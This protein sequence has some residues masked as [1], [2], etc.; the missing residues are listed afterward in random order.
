[1]ETVSPSSLYLDPAIREARAEYRHVN[2][3][4]IMR[5]MKRHENFKVRF[6]VPA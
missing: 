5:E 3:Q 6:A 4:S 1:M 2:I